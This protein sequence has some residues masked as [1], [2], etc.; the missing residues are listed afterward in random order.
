[1]F[2]NCDRLEIYIGGKHVAAAQPDRAGF[3]HLSYPPFFFDLTADGTGNPELRI[4]GYVGGKVVL[5]RSFSSDGSQ[6][7]FVL[8]ADDQELIADGSDATRLV[9]QVVDRFGAPRLLAGGDVTLQ[10]DGP[11]TI[12]GDNPFHLADSGGAGAVWIRT[13]SGTAGRIRVTATHS[14]LGRRSVEIQV[15]LNGGR[16]R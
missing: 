8:A 3:P 12:M 7:Q 6:D 5:S 11:G 14:T 15:R 13:R 16:S 9:F 2:S 4:D 10:I 1:M